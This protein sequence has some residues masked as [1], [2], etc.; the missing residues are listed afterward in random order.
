MGLESWWRIGLWI[1]LASVLGGRAWLVDRECRRAREEA[2]HYRRVAREWSASSF[3][4]RRPAGLNPIVGSKTQLETS[5][6]SSLRRGSGVGSRSF[7]SAW[8]AQ[9]KRAAEPPLDSAQETRATVRGSEDED[10]AAAIWSV[11]EARARRLS[12]AW[13]ATVGMNGLQRVAIG[14]R[15]VTWVEEGDRLQGWELLHIDPKQLVWI[16]RVSEGRH[17]LV[18]AVLPFRPDRE[19]GESH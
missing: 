15:R 5:A 8:D 14:E 2:G 3:R 16:D 19:E 1:A 11:P 10:G 9:P 18:S 4:R 13:R 7:G 12:W 6:S 17:D